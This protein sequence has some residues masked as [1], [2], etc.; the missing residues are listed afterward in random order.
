MLVAEEAS[1]LWHVGAL[2]ILLQ[3]GTPPSILLYLFSVT[4]SVLRFIFIVAH[5]KHLLSSSTLPV[6]VIYDVLESVSDVEYRQIPSSSAP[7]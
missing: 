7:L 4:L 6:S 3:S 1:R 5:R 2:Q